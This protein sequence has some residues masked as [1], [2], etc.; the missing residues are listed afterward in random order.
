VFHSNLHW[1]RQS[2]PQLICCVWLTQ[3]WREKRWRLDKWGPFLNEC[4]QLSKEPWQMLLSCSDCFHC[5]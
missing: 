5:S 1:Q 2:S 4:D 3:I